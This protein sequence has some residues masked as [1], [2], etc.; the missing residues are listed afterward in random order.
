MTL[1]GIAEC[2]LAFCKLL[3]RRGEILLDGVPASSLPRDLCLELRLAL[4][5]LAVRQ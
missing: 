4:R 1:F 3:L 5:P 2:R